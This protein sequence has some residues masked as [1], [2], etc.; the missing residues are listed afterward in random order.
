MITKN[1]LDFFQSHIKRSSPIERKIFKSLFPSTPL[2]KDLD[3]TGSPTLQFLTI[4]SMT[5]RAF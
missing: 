5:P 1:N 3:I 4:L 2:P